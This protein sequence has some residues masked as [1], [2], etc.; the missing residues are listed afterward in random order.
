MS[1]NS[2]TDYVL[3]SYTVLPDQSFNPIIPPHSAV[4]LHVGDSSTSPYSAGTKTRVIFSV[5]ATTQFGENIYVVGSTQELGGWDLS[6]A[7]SS[8]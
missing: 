5:E 8:D 7:V 2:M 4:A 3:A 1:R 6:K